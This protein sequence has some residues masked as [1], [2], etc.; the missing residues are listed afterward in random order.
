M[1]PLP[2]CA[3]KSTEFTDTQ[4][5]F[6]AL[7]ASTLSNCLFI[8]HREVSE[9]SFPQCFEGRFSHCH[10]SHRAAANCTAAVFTC[11][12]VPAAYVTGPHPQSWASGKGPHSRSLPASPCRLQTRTGPERCREIV[13]WVLCC[14]CGQAVGDV[15]LLGCAGPCRCFLVVQTGCG[16]AVTA[17]VL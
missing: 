11:L 9:S 13:Q 17:P 3:S 4:K 1:R 5:V 7:S 8:R 2:Q 14:R 16:V 10:R 6:R 15:R 12:N